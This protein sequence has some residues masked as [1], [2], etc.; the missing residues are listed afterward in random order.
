MRAQRE[1]LAVD[2]AAPLIIG[3]DPAGS[4]VDRTAFAYRRG[5]VIERVEVVRG[6]DTMEIAGRIVRIIQEHEPARVYVDSTGM[7]IGVVDR[8]MEQGFDRVVQAVNFAS[9][10]LEPTT[11]DEHGKRAG[12]PIAELSCGAILSERCRT[13]ACGYRMIRPCWPI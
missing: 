9:K 13:S 2:P 5:R 6:L 4:G 8:L 12:Q 1:T 3:C 11:F 10:P 7:G